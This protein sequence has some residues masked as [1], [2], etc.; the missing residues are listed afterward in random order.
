MYVYIKQSLYIHMHI[1]IYMYMWTIEESCWGVSWNSW[2]RD[3]DC[4]F[5]GLQ[6]AA[7]TY[8]NTLQHTATIYSTLQHA[9]TSSDQ[10]HV[11]DVCIAIYCNTL[12][13]TSTHCDT[14]QTPQSI[15]NL[16]YVHIEQLGC[17]AGNSWNAW[18]R[19]SPN[20]LQHTTTHCNSLQLTATHCNTLQHTIPRCNTLQ[21]TWTAS[22]QSQSQNIVE[23]TVGTVEAG[24][25]ALLS[26][27]AG[28]Q[29]VVQVSAFIHII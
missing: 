18:G 25:E 3:K 12:Q 9:A 27:W 7:T 2:G 4:V 6:H 11:Q 13:H 21:H 28:I 14:L 15:G 5:N 8:C 22:E 26:S 10:S 23:E 1:R 29:G 17:C 20:A 19:A 24:D 16:R